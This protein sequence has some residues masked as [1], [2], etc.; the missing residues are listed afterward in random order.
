MRIAFANSARIWGGAEVMTETLLRGLQARGHDVVLL[1]RPGSP[2]LER[3]GGD[4]PCEPVPGGFDLNPAAVWRCARALR[5][6]GSQVLMTMTQKDPRI[7]GVAARLVRVPVVVRHPMDVPFRQRLHHR[8]YFGWVPTHFAANSR[9]TRDT[10]LRSAP[11]LDPAD[12]T[13]IHNGID[14]ERA[15][16]AAPAELGLPEGAVAVGFVGRFEVGKG[17]LDL[18]AA[19]PQIA[20]EVPEAHLLLVGRGGNREREVRE[21]L[22]S[23]PRVHWLGFR[24]DVAA[25]MRALDLLVLP[26]HR[27]GFGLVLAEAMA[28]ETAVVASRASAIPEIV[29]DGV[30]GRLFEPR[31][32]QALARAV[33]ELARSAPTRARMGRAGAAR[34]RREFTVAGMLD[35]YERLFARVAGAG[36]VGRG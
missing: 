14:V 32:P 21:R 11:W 8:V 20:R 36:E 10:M 13:V 24:P 1:C 26:S 7:A 23:A 27:E 35:D 22:S 15:A 28:A 25:V 16:R 3:L 6:H 2:V 4:V 18:A 33:V 12:V 9:A 19:W 31:S 5:G 30:E 29:E 17:A 34:V